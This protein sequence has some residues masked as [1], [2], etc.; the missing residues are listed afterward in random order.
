MLPSGFRDSLARRY[1]NRIQLSPA[2]IEVI[3]GAILARQPGCNLLVFGLGYDSPL[4]A[5]INARGSTLFI[6]HSQEWER[7]ILSDHP[8]LNAIRVD[9]GRHTV[10]TSLKSPDL[11]IAAA[12]VPPLLQRDWDVILIDGPAGSRPDHPGRAL[13]IC[14]AAQM[15]ARPTH[16]FVHDC[17]RPLEHAFIGRTLIGGSPFVVVRGFLGRRNLFWSIGCSP[18][19]F[20]RNPDAPGLAEAASS[21]TSG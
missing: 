7:R 13:P 4:W 21:P 16:V 12:A 15:R 2:Q 18:A 3:G 5:D 8:Q 20:A 19:F 9:F 1:D 10:A 6:E 14:W 11:T 17:E